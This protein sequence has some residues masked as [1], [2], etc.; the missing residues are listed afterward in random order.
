MQLLRLFGGGVRSRDTERLSRYG[1]VL[2]TVLA[3]RRSHSMQG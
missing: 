2:S 3:L 1:G